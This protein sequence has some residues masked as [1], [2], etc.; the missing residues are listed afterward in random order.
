MNVHM[1]QTDLE[2]SERLDALYDYEVLDTQPEAAF[3]HL[4]ALAARLMDVPVAMISLIDRDR[5][6]LKAR[7]G[8]EAVQIPREVSFCKHVVATRELIAVEDMR[9][10]PRF[11]S[12]PFVAGEL[13]VRSYVGAPLRT[14]T[15]EVLGTLC[16]IENRHTRSFSDAELE[17]LQA[18]ADAVM[19]HMETR[20]AVQS[21]QAAHRHMEE[22]AQAQAAFISLTSHELRTPVA[23]MMGYAELIQESAQGGD[24][25][26]VAQDAGCIAAAGEHVVHLLDDLLDLAKINSGQLEIFASEFQ[27]DA[28]FEEVVSSL[29]PLV[30]Q[31][32]NELASLPAQVS[33]RQDFVRLKQILINLVTNANKFTQQGTISLEATQ[34]DD[35]LTICVR[36]TGM[37][38]PEDKFDVLFDAFSQVRDASSRASG[39]GLGLSICKGLADAMGAHITV[40]SELGTGSCF[41]LVLPHSARV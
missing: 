18:L 6:W 15:G 12:N 28:L 9:A 7:R 3:D 25:E 20:R 4:V 11:A 10:D 27:L 30:S 13:S 16:V 36:D 41:S 37:G 38:I 22:I 35:G 1:E 14:E 23:S 26:E 34:G 32:E 5:Q 39:V 29:R 2:E 8:V 31:R 24:Y 40:E 33:V 19:A 17:V 21:A